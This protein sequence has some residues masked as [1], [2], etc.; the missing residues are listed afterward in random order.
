MTDQFGSPIE[1]LILALLICNPLGGSV[2][3]EA[4]RTRDARLARVEAK[5][6]LLLQHAGLQYDPVKDVPGA[7]LEALRA[8]KKIE[9]IKLFCE[10]ASVGLKE[11]KDFVEEVQRRLH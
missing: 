9:A 4:D 2:K 1:L 6:D 10:S 7:V 5:L 3:R 11:A 8:G